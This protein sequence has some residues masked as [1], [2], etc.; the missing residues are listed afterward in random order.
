MTRRHV[1]RRL[2]RALRDPDAGRVVEID[3]QLAALLRRKAEWLGLP[4]GASYNDV[5]RAV[6]LEPRH[7]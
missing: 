2:R 5:L 7:E 4:R 3:G 1:G 6:L